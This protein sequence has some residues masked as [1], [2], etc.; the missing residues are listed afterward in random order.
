MPS[1]L[2]F[3]RDICCCCCKGPS[4]ALFAAGVKAWRK[5]EETR[6]QQ[7]LVEAV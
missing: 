3:V 2:E 4:D 6:K 1:I 5:Y 7:Y